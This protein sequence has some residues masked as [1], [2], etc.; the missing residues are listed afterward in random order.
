MPVEDDL[1]EHTRVYDEVRQIY[2]GFPVK[3]FLAQLALDIGNEFLERV[4][5]RQAIHF[6]DMAT[7]GYGRIESG[8]VAA[9]SGAGLALKMGNRRKAAEFARTW[10]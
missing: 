8:I 2:E 9:I 5:W 6:Y 10:V 7:Q 3:P 4:D 1:R